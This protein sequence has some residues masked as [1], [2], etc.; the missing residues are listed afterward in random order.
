MKTM[1]QI[2]DPKTNTLTDDDAPYDKPLYFDTATINQLATL[3]TL[4]Q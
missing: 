4:S 1:A 2:D 3:M